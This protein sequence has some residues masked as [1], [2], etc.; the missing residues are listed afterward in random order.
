MAATGDGKGI[1]PL[2]EESARTPYSVRLN[3]PLGEAP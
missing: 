2:F 1:R 3:R